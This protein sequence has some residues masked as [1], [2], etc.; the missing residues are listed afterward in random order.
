MLIQTRL[1]RIWKRGRQVS[2]ATALHPRTPSFANKTYYITLYPT[3]SCSLEPT[4][5]L[6]VRSWVLLVIASPGPL[7][8]LDWLGRSQKAV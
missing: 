2:T 5:E 8:L 7:G 3:P 1:R 4:L 6:L